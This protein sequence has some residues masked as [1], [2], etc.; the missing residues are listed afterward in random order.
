M[1][2]LN[3][4]MMNSATP[5]DFLR[6]LFKLAVVYSALFLFIILLPGSVNGQE[7]SGDNPDIPPQPHQE[8]LRKARKANSS[9]PALLSSDRSG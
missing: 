8:F 3:E 2:K 9:A 6:S 4:T 1:K 5:A 7:S